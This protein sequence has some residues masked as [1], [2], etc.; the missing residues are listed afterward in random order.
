[1]IKKLINFIKYFYEFLNK[2]KK[3]LKYSFIKK[4]PTILNNYLSSKNKISV[5]YYTNINI[6]LYFISI[7]RIFLYK[8][9]KIILTNLVENLYIILIG[10]L[11]ICIFYRIKNKKYNIKIF[12]KVLLSFSGFTLYIM[13]ALPIIANGEGV[14]ISSE[15]IVELNA[16]TNGTRQSGNNNSFDYNK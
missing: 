9:K 8:N 10:L 12:I 15:E 4:Q 7:A 11:C 2:I 3:S 14:P 5:I 6:I 13:K 1:M 16:F